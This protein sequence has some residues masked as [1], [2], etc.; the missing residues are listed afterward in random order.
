MKSI[1]LFAGAGG[2]AM[3]G[4]LA[5]FEHR[6]VIEWDSWACET[7]RENQRR[8]FPLVKDW[9]VIEGDVRNF[10]FA[11][12]G[13]NLDLVSGGPPCQPFS[14]CG[15][16]K[17]LNDARDMFPTA[18]EVVRST[19]P[20][21]FVF[22]NV[23]GLARPAFGN[24]LQYIILQLTFPEIKRKREEE[25]LQHLA[26]LE[27]QKTKGIF[28][29][30]RYKV[31]FR[32]L[33]AADYGIPQKRARVF[34][35]GFREDQHYEWSFPKPTHS[36]DALLFEQWI[37]GEYWE[38]HDVPTRQ[39]PKIDPRVKT[40]VEKMEMQPQLFKLSFNPWRTVRDAISDLPQPTKNGSETDALNHRYQPGAKAYPGH[41]G[42][43]LDEP[44]K[45]L[46][47]GDHGVPGGENMLRHPNG[48]VRYFTVR[49]AARLQGFPDE[50]FFN[51]SW[52]ETMRQLGNAV[53]VPLAEIVTGSVARCLANNNK[54]AG[55][56]H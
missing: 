37:S 1:E 32:V 18:V 29:G 33:N 17:G 49:E 42:S 44:S 35:V 25:W 13:E 3:G 11:S 41:T 38:K 4:G 40:K 24:Y 39:R 54:P 20:R 30:L 10:D 48:K 8:G 16:H 51:G 15:K 22:E 12:I 53:P 9:P 43:P 52:T 14:I 36:L 34:I 46:K 50:Y 6:A 7:I 5:G 21:A 27:Q 26:R 19:A 23:R 55:S 31:V 28:S 2:L 56:V 47:A 45:T